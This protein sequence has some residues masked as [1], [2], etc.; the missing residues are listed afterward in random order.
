MKAGDWKFESKALGSI[1]RVLTYDLRTIIGW[2]VQI[3]FL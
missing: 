2:W 3:G 1:H